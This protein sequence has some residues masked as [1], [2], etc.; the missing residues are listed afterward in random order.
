MVYNAGRPFLLDPG[1]WLRDATAPQMPG[2]SSFL[3]EA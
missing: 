2:V 1:T 3:W